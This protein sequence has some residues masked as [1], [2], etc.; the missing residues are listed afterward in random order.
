MQA[1]LYASL[2]SGWLGARS[3]SAGEVV[4]PLAGPFTLPAS[5]FAGWDSSGAPTLAAPLVRSLGAILAGA[6]G[7]WPAS[8]APVAES[9]AVRI[10][11]ANLP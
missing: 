7:Q 9:T 5:R 2:G 11:L 10:A 8:A 6:R 4:Q 1:R 3:V